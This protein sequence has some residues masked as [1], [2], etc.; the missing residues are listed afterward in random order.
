MDSLEETES[1]I[2]QIEKDVVDCRRCSLWKTRRNP[3][4]GDGAL[5]ARVMFIGEAPGYYEDVQGIP[6]VGKAGKIYDELLSSINLERKSVYITN[7]LKCRPP[8]NR[9]PFH[10]EIKACTPYLDRQIMAIKPYVIVTLGNFA[11]SYVLE[12]F[13]LKAEKIGAIHGNMFRIENL[14]FNSK[15]VPLYHPAFAV[16]NPKIRKVLLKDFESIARALYE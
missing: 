3:V 5:N 11:S 12:K 2:K 15:I 8:G 7:I 6:F 14:V 1:K 16:Y 9:N 10:T 13:G 4:V